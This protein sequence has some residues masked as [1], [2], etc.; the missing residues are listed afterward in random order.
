[1]RIMNENPKA[2]LPGGKSR[3]KA[4]SRSGEL[5][6]GLRGAKAVFNQWFMANY[7]ILKEYISLS[8][9]FD[10]DAFHE[11]YLV[12]VT[13]KEMTANAKDFRKMFLSTYK[14]VS[15]HTLNESYIVCHPDD[16]FFAMLP[17]AVGAETTPKEYDSLAK[18]IVNFIRSTFPVIQQSILQ[19]RVQGYSLKDTADTLNIPERQVKTDMN[20]V[21]CRTR[22][23]FAYAK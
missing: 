1:M 18:E 21:V 17:E 20:A 8:G 19:M 3:T 5:R 11:A 4:L 16:L 7:A 22:E 15:R 14:A 12:V 9:Y 10:E 6:P 23:Q 2:T 13:D